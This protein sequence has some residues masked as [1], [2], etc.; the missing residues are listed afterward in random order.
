M[1]LKVQISISGDK[2][3]I[4]KLKKLGDSFSDWTSTLRSTGDYLMDVYSRQNFAMNGA[5]SGER[6]AELSPKY[7]LW[8]SKHYPG[9]GILE[10]TGAM[11]K[12]FTMSVG[13]RK[14]EIQNVVKYAY[15]HQEGKGLPARRLISVNENVKTKIIGIFKEGIREKLS[16]ALR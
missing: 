7:E 13:A 15:Y 2:K 3:V 9:H 6:W 4:A 1:A 16:V 12:G 10:R 8:K 14:L 11:K 5:I